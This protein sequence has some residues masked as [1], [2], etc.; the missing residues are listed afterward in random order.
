MPI[1]V[2]IKQEAFDKVDCAFRLKCDASHPL[3]NPYNR[4]LSRIVHH[5]VVGTVLVSE[6]M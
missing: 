5:D 3:G 2:R 1:R 6:D 4:M